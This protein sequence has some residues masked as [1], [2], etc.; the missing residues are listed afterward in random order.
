LFYNE[1]EKVLDLFFE[2]LEVIIHL[3]K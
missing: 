3:N 2:V 1:E